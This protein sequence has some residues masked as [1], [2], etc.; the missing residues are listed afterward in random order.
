MSVFDDL[1]KNVTDLTEMWPG[2][3]RQLLRLKN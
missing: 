2:N 1:M 3:Q